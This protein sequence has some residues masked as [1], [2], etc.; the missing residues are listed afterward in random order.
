[1]RQLASVFDIT[2]SMDGTY[3]AK[4]ADTQ[5][6]VQ[7]NENLN[8]YQFYCTCKDALMCIHIEEMQ[9]FRK[10]AAFF[11]DPGLWINTNPL[12][13]S[14]PILVA[15]FVGYWVKLEPFEDDPG[16]TVVK[17]DLNSWR[18]RSIHPSAAGFPIVKMVADLAVMS[19]NKGFND[20]L[21]MITEGEGTGDITSSVFDAFSAFHLEYKPTYNCKAHWHKGDNE[22][23]MQARIRNPDTRGKELA[24]LFFTESCTP[25]AAPAKLTNFD[26]LIPKGH[27]VST[28]PFASRAAT[29]FPSV[30]RP[31]GITL[32]PDPR[33]QVDV[34]H[35]SS[36]YTI[37]PNAW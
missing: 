9:G 6:G 23:D 15:P 37:S 34:H 16:F 17:H 7:Y 8:M 32:N 22:A 28:P 31:G 20:E 26:D 4:I 29:A 14:I 11:Q 5:I 30:G 13:V 33:Y 25:C 35:P 10:D 2:Q 36:D 24:R 21:C 19:G 18:G 3:T 1:M 27:N 12:Y